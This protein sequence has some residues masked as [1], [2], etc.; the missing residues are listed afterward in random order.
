[1]RPVSSTAAALVPDSPQTAPELAR[2]PVCCG[3]ARIKFE[4]R[5]YPVHVCGNCT[6]HFV[7]LDLNEQHTNSVYTDQ[8]F[9]GSQE[10]YP[11]Y[12]SEGAALRL[13]GRWYGQLL[14][15]YSRGERL[16]DT[17][18]AAGFL[19]KGFEDAGWRGTGIEP[20]A[21]MVQY[22]R[23]Q[24]NVDVRLGTLEQWKKREP[25]E[26]VTMIQV[27]SHFFD[28]RRAMEVTRAVTKPGSLW[29]VETWDR[30]SLTA[31][32]AGRKWHEFNPPS[33]V[34]WFSREGLV[35]L[36]EQ[37]GF[38]PVAAGRPEKRINVEHARSV[39]SQGKG[40]ASRLA[41]LGLSLLPN[42]TTL[43]YPGNDVFW[44][45]FRRGE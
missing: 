39:L 20:N 8:Y 7:G 28:L 22:A 15:R 19:L 11:D 35:Y 43:R 13:H 40:V 12:C 29:L 37:Y 25:F 5:A 44:M 17:G 1:M 18:S 32:M 6:H 21:S 42:S 36:A 9:K 16:L 24:N 33:V 31:R 38:K 45:L 23:H 10:G 4:I 41:G 26:A 34:H 2:C 27:I 30:D 3:E 14:R